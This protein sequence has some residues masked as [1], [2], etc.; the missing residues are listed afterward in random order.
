MAQ[1]SIFDDELILPGVITEVVNDYNAGYDTS[2]FGTTEAVTII[3]TAFNGPVGMPIPV[4]SPEYAK[5]AFGGSFDALTRREATLVPEI[6]DAWERGCRT[7]YAVRVSGKDMYKDYEL[8]IESN[9]KLRVSGK[10]PHNE[11]KKCFIFYDANQRNLTNAGSIKIYKPADRTTIQEKMQGVVDN[12][13]SVLVNEINLENYSITKSSKLI[14]LLD[15]VNNH[16]KNNVLRLSIVDENGVELTG[17]AKAV[18]VLSV[19]D[20]FPGIYTICKQGN[21]EDAISKTNVKIN[22][23]QDVKDAKPYELFQEALWKELIINTDVRQ[24]YPIFASRIE[25]FKD[26]YPKLAID[27]DYECFSKV[28][29]LDQMV[30]SDEVDYE[31]V[32]LDPFE[33]Y[34]KLG[35]GFVKTAKLEEKR[36]SKG[37]YTGKYKV[38]LPG[39]DDSQR[40]VGINDGIYSILENHRSDYTV[41]AGVSAETELEGKFPRKEDF[42]VVDRN[43]IEVNHEVDGVVDTIFL[44]KQKLADDDFSMKANYRIMINDNSPIESLN[45]DII[46]A[47]ISPEKYVRIPV[48]GKKY[49]SLIFEGIEDGQLALAINDNVYID[50]PGR[51]AEYRKYNVL[52]DGASAAFLEVVEEVLG[53]G[54]VSLADVRAVNR[55]N[56]DADQNIEVGDKVIFIEEIIGQ[57]DVNIMEFAG[58]PDVLD[59]E[60]LDFGINT[61]E[62]VMFN[63]KNGT[64]ERVEKDILGVGD[65]GEDSYEDVKLLV[66]I[67]EMLVI[68]NQ[69]VIEENVNGVVN[70]QFGQYKLAVETITAGSSNK[71][72]PFVMADGNIY[73]AQLSF[74]NDLNDQFLL[75]DKDGVLIKDSDDCY[76]RYKAIS[77]DLMPLMSVRALAAK[78]MKED[79]YTVICAE[80]DMPQL[81]CD[82]SSNDTIIC[83]YS[84]EVEF[85][86][87][88]EIMDKLNKSEELKYRFEF[89]L[90]D[91][92][93]A[94]DELPIPLLGIGNSMEGIIY[95]RN[96]YIPY[97]T[98]D[99]FA[100]HLA[101]HCLYTQLKTYP[102]HGIIGCNKLMGVN[103][104]T[105][106]QRVDDLCSYDFDL[107]AKK[108]NGNYMFDAN[109]EPYPIGRCVSI[110]FMQYTVG[111]G[112]GYNYISGGAA[113]YAG[114]V[115][116]L[117]VDRSSTNQEIKIGD[118]SY[119]LSNYQLG[120][121]NSK[122]IV[123]AK[124]STNKGVVIVDGI[125]Q[126][127]V[128]SAYRRLATAKTINIVDKTLRNTLE[129]YIGLMDSLTTRNSMNTAIKSVLNDLKGIIIND[130]KFK[131][132]TDASN[133]NLGVIRIDYV[134]VPL[135]EIREIRNRVEI[136]AQ[137]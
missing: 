5:Q 22:L 38:V 88:E 20:I 17:A 95:D 57:Q 59:Y 109:N 112:D 131:I 134:L 101:Q 66:Q 60:D 121:L 24:P 85:S 75:R 28:G 92:S 61:G 87:Q 36:N 124:N 18:Q 1:K 122:G 73:S 126:A 108:D 53:Q 49:L 129:P 8:A 120:R 123:C 114:M 12:I 116:A 132:Y 78:E 100:R 65:H 54:Q 70:K 82:L 102:T 55:L 14:D 107:Y 47:N 29:F 115:S 21:H 58:D 69:D 136:T 137:F 68:Y 86:S 64:F 125:T 111:T 130:Y 42:K 133:G 106:A 127:P 35:K 30:I 45:H 71:L 9:L 15:V 67:G 79:E 16:S 105:I 110:V 97:T 52:N 56:N 103:L 63:K 118:L 117:P 2:E 81:P 23:V 93:S 3:G 32:E 91:E 83:V 31:E 41:L 11:N 33:L 128:T 34:M 72:Y 98:T 37:E 25:N 10:Y 27:L 43:P 46:M 99:N 113:G 6:Y 13:N 104:S 74:T 26:S 39:E 7:I 135:N 4:Y 90:T 77:P 62:L 50:I 40:V 76:L 96:K 94:V 119:T 51:L 48:I 84:S 44:A 89:I 80:K 19:G